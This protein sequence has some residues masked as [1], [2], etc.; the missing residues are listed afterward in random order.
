MCICELQLHRRY[1][2]RRDDKRLRGGGRGRVREGVRVVA[3]R[4]RHERRGE[5]RVHHGNVLW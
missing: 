3:E 1:T 4:E 5:E 2:G